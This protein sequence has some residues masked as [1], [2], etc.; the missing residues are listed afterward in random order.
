MVLISA[1]D[2][3]MS[4]VYTRITIVLPLS[5]NTSIYFY[6]PFKEERVHGFANVGQSVGM[7]VGLSVGR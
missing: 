3:T 2:V 6:T 7:S 5:F 4:T 1:R